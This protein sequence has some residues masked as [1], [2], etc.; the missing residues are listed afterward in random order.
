MYLRLRAGRPCTL[1][2]THAVTRQQEYRRLAYRRPSPRGSAILARGWERVIGSHGGRKRL[3]RKRRPARN[4]TRPCRV[5]TPPLRAA[6]RR[7]YVYTFKNENFPLKIILES[8]YLFLVDK[9]ITRAL[10]V[11][12]RTSAEESWSAKRKRRNDRRNGP[13]VAR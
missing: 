4:C 5:G 9:R 13:S 3:A 7:Q 1:D 8:L 2:R 12:I 6:K 11:T 10:P